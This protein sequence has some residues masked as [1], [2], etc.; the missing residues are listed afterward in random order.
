MYPESGPTPNIGHMEKA[1]T[2]G[3][4]PTLHEVLNEP[5]VRQLM[6]SDEVTRPDLLSLLGRF[7]RA[8]SHEDSPDK[9]NRGDQAWRSQATVRTV[10]R[11]QPPSRA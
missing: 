3:V 7:R 9:A 2:F 10:E 5:I 11:L 4:E 1:E 8:R 6:A